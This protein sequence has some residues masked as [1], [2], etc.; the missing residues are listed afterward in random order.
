[1]ISW[2]KL[3][4]TS[5]SL[6]QKD[7][8]DWHITA[9]GRTQTASEVKNWQNDLM[10]VRILGELPLSEATLLA[11]TEC[12]SFSPLEFSVDL[13][14]EEKFVVNFCPPN[15][16]TGKMLIRITNEL[17][18]ISRRKVL[19]FIGLTD[20]PFDGLYRDESDRY[21]Q[22]FQKWNEEFNNLA[23]VVDAKTLLQFLMINNLTRINMSY[24]KTSIYEIDLASKQFQPM[25]K[26]PLS[27]DWNKVFLLKKY[28]EEVRPLRV[29]KGK[30]FQELEMIK[31]AFN[32]VE[33]QLYW[34]PQTT[35]A[36][37]DVGLIY[38]PRIDLT[39]TFPGKFL[40][41]QLLFVQ[42]FYSKK[43]DGLARFLEHPEAKTQL[44]E[45]QWK[46]LACY[47]TACNSAHEFLRFYDTRP[48]QLDSVTPKELAVGQ[49]SLLITL[50]I[51]PA[52]GV[53]W[54]EMSPKEFYLFAG[55]WEL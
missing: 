24:P 41:S 49:G 42:N 19:W 32:D 52:Q 45:P 36:H 23:Y 54:L 4:T 40:A 34:P 47:A 53:W 28:L 26:H 22:S 7:K 25:P 39:F 12:E 29:V 15:S 21:I 8:D 11:S 31:G 18:S 48:S 16:I 5:W 37:E 43:I 10:N 30:S 27:I 44:S 2:K 55:Q 20:R 50:K 51:Y 9:L 46:N 33:V 17:K 38:V 6:L 14:S 35:N 1:M 3:E 13:G